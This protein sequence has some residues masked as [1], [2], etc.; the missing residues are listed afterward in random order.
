MELKEYLEILKKNANLFLAVVALIVLIALGYFFFQPVS[1]NTSLTLNI[2]RL[3]IQ[4]TSDF[5]YDDFY[6]L[7]ADEKFAE[8][9]VEWLK[10][11]RIVA[12]IY[13]EANIST[14]NATLRQLA[15]KIK[16]E[17]MSSQI[18]AVS[19]SSSDQKTSEKIASSVVKI[20]SETTANLNKDQKEDTWFEIM[21]Q[22]PVIIK[23]NPD[24]GLIA[25]ASFFLGLF[26]GFWI[27][28]I[29]HYLE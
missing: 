22:N 2:T 5:R 15:K 6:R 26:L 11:P 17:K 16:V 8:T 28:M 3:G 19:F 24:F 13:K 1:Y 18:I 14:Q 7:Q 21:A 4:N 9:V 27:V 10:S 20:I 25:L 12:D 23:N 29:K